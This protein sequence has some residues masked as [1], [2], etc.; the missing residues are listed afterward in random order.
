VFGIFGGLIFMTYYLWLVFAVIALSCLSLTIS[1]QDQ[2]KFFMRSLFTMIISLLVSLPFLLPLIKVYASQGSEN[3]Q[4]ALFTITNISW[5][6]LFFDSL[7]WKSLLMLGG[8]IAII[9]NYRVEK[10]KPL[11][12]ATATVYIWWTMGLG[13]LLLFAVPMQ[14]FRGFYF[15]L[16]TILAIGLSFGIAQFWEYIEKYK[17]SQAIKIVLAV[18]GLLLFLQLSVFGSFID[19]PIV[20]NR[21]VAS[22][23][24]PTHLKSLVSFLQ[25]QPGD[26]VTLNAVPSLLAWLPINNVIYFNQHNS[27]PAAHFS[28]RLAYIKSLSEAKNPEEFLELTKKSPAGPIRRLIVYRTEN[29]YPLFFHIDKTMSGFEEIS[30]TIP[31]HLISD[32]YFKKVYTIENYEVWEVR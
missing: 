15:F 1:K 5:R 30:I 29:G 2:F 23:L 19:E 16:P 26:E 24:A 8:F 18:T 11:L 12:A 3:W 4:A 31:S 14:E 22:K 25:N 27:H 28:D 32:T 21:L 10:N 6:T 7:S 17:N 13:T 9:Y 20:H